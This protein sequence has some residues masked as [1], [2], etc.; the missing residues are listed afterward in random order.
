[1]YQETCLCLSPG[2]NLIQ[3]L[4]SRQKI[5]V[6]SADPISR[7]LLSPFFPCV[8]DIQ[9]HAYPSSVRGRLD[10][11]AQVLDL[12]HKARADA[13]LTKVKNVEEEASGG[14]EKAVL[15]GSGQG[16]GR[17]REEKVLKGRGI[18]SRSL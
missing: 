16:M 6:V 2:V 15:G 3:A 7:L 10:L 5:E 12:C 14:V 17:A 11:L 8:K 9:Y 18:A 13:E 1:M 4:D